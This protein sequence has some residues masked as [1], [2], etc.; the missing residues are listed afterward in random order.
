MPETAH[1]T[2]DRLHPSI[3]GFAAVGAFGWT[4]LLLVDFLVPVA[5]PVVALVSVLILRGQIRSVVQQLADSV[6]HLARRMQEGK[7]GSAEAKFAT[8]E[9]LL[10]PSEI[11]IKKIQEDSG[12]SRAGES[13][14]GQDLRVG[15]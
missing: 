10:P 12:A 4:K 5:W 3:T 1:G 13:P 11:E 15:T 9:S 6:G 8:V 14:E 7:I 2:A